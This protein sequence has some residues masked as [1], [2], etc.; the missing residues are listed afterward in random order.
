MLLKAT[1]SREI[2]RLPL[3][4]SPPLVDVEGHAAAES[5]GEPRR[6]VEEEEEEGGGVKVISF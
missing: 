3:L 1:E 6:A 2:Y 4:T 5:S